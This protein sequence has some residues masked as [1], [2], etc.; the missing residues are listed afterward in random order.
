LVEL[1]CGS[2]LISFVDMNWLLQG[3]LTNWLAALL[4]FVGGTAVGVLKYK[5]SRWAATALFALGGSALVASIIIGFA[6]LSMLP[7]RVTPGNAEAH[8][9][10]W[11]D[12]WSFEVSKLPDAEAIFAFRARFRDG[13]PPVLVRHLKSSNQSL[14]LQATITTTPEEQAA[15]RVLPREKKMLTKDD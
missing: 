15:I 4:V 7:D 14:L 8:V 2:N 10:D 3:L 6:A 11:L 9:R 5:G 12:H 13:H 1:Y